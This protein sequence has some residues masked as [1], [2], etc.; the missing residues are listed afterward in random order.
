MI[1]G[2]NFKKKVYF[3]T[4]TQKN[5]YHIWISLST[6]FR[7]KL[8]I[9]IFLTKFAKKSRYFQSKTD[10]TDTT[11]EF[12]IFELGFV[13]NFTFNNQ[14]WFFCIKFHFEQTILIFFCIKFHFEQTILIFFLYQISLWTNNFEF[15]DQICPRK[16]FMVKNRKSEHH[17]WNPLLQI[18]LGTKFQ[19]KLS[20]LN[21]CWS[22]TGKMNTTYF[23]NSAC[24]NY[25]SAKFQL[26]LTIF[27]FWTKFPQKGIS[28]RKQ[29]K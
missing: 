19:L 25:S 20:I 15:L 5:E 11:I 21:F 10:K 28:S 3:R 14:F 16:I 27:I 9:A 29:K 22:K 12:C 6:S 7:L 13:S 23:L 8:T 17:H 24:S 18:N 2:T 26:K 4:K 1:F